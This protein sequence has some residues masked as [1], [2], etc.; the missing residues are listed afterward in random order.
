MKTRGTRASGARRHEARTTS[1]DD[2]TGLDAPR[3]RPGMT[4]EIMD[5]APQPR[6]AHPAYLAG[7]RTDESRRFA[8]PRGA[9][10]G[11]LRTVAMHA[12]HAMKRLASTLQPMR[13][14][15]RCGCSSGWPCPWRDGS[16]I[17]V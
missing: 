2:T 3:A 5:A 13:S 11:A 15:Y 16:L 9:P 7:I 6:S 4:H 1:I 10:W 8:F 17:P 14:L 12:A